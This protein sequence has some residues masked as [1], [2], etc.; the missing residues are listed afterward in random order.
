MSGTRRLRRGKGMGQGSRCKG[1]QWAEALASAGWATSSGH[2]STPMQH[3]PC[4]QPPA[5]HRKR[6]R[7]GI[8]VTACRP[9]LILKF[10][11]SI[12]DGLFL[13]LFRSPRSFNRTS[14]CLAGTGPCRWISPSIHQNGLQVRHTAQCCPA[15]SLKPPKPPL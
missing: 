7:D 1:R 5:H 6:R 9:P 15:R 8:P 13:P 3:A 12:H 10:P 11:R 4:S 2:Q 14:R